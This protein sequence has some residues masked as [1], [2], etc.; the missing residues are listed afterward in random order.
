VTWAPRNPLC[1][2]RQRI[3]AGPS[4]HGPSQRRS[5]RIINLLGV[6]TTSGYIPSSPWSNGWAGGC[7]FC[8]TRVKSAIVFSLMLDG[9]GG[10]DAKFSAVHVRSNGQKA[11]PNLDE[12][13]VVADI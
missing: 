1:R 5:I 9:S 7:L 3:V 4:T 13:R 6:G 8:S 10:F 2:A 11:G 12:D